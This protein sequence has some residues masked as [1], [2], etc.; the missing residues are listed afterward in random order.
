MDAVRDVD[1][2]AVGSG[3]GGS[4][5]HAGRRYSYEGY[6]VLALE[7]AARGQVLVRRIDPRHPL[8]GMG[9]RFFVAAERL[10]AE[11][12]RYHGDAIPG[13]DAK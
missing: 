8:T 12:M 11:P 7:D 9:P 1:R 3:E 10:V 6:P 13:D 5:I 4:V 2:P